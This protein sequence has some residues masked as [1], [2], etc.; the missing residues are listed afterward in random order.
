MARLQNNGAVV[1][2]GL[3]LKAPLPDGG[4]SPFELFERTRRMHR[5]P[6]RLKARHAAASDLYQMPHGGQLVDGAQLGMAL[7]LDF[8]QQIRI[9]VGLVES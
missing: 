8:L 9:E 4:H 2:P 1:E 3:P 7:G 6:K 5:L